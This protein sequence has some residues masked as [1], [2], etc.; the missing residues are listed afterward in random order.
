M[1]LSFSVSPKRVTQVLTYVVLC[2]VLASITGQFAKL[3]LGYETL[4]GFVRLFSV[5]KE[6]N[7]PTLYSCFALLFCSSMLFL[8]AS[9]RKRAGDRYSLHWWVLSII[10]LYLSVDEATS[11]H[12]EAINPVRSALNTSGLLYFAW[13]I[14]A[15]ALVLLFVLAYLR[16]LAH[17]PGKTRRLFLLAGLVYLAG[18]L[19]MELVGAYQTD[20][21]G[22]ENMA[23]V[24]IVSIE[25]F[26]EMMG[27]VVFIYALL[28]Y[29]SLQMKV[30]AVNLQIRIEEV[31]R[32]KLQFIERAISE[33]ALV[34]K[35]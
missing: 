25:E 9:I 33:K 12:E 14:P 13:V 8:I 31:P 15:A 26:F 3:V 28:S 29:I 5:D 6:G 20:F 11:I 34:K 4:L 2:L 1:N 16:F 17:L 18:A 7:I 35:K 23:Y 30:K 19:G 32:P 27:I 21:Y 22:Q 24:L 10:F